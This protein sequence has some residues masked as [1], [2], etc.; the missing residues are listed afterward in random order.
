MV[1]VAYGQALSSTVKGPAFKTYYDCSGQVVPRSR[2]PDYN[3]FSQRGR[4][5][6]RALHARRLIYYDV[7]A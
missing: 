3:C 7:R 4:H 6:G 1:L 5:S 2:H